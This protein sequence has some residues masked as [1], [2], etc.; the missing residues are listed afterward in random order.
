MVDNQYK[1]EPELFVK[2]FG[3][4]EGQ[5]MLE[6]LSNFRYGL[7]ASE[8]GMKCALMLAKVE[9]SREMVQYL[10]DGLRKAQNAARKTQS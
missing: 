4:L 6:H 2:V 5:R 10:K 7:P 9:G 8:D 1:I 3:T